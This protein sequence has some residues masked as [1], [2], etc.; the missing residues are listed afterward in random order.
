M[1]A[2]HITSS[3]LQFVGEDQ[4]TRIPRGINRFDVCGADPWSAAGAPVGLLG[5]SARF[6]EQVQGT[7]ADQGVCPTCSALLLLALAPL[8]AQE[9][10]LHP[11][12]G[13]RHRDRWTFP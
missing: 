2:L 4:C 1:L 9:I 7:C 10:K 13:P 11:T 3:K 12:S 6:A 8:A 5:V